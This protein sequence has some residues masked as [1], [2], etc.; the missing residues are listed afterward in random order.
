[1]TL[2]DCELYPA[3]LPPFLLSPPSLLSLPSHHPSSLPPFS[4]PPSFPSSP[5]PPS[6]QDPNVIGTDVS[7]SADCTELRQPRVQFTVEPLI[8][9]TFNQ[10]N[11]TDEEVSFGYVCSRNRIIQVAQNFTRNVSTYVYIHNYILYNY[12]PVHA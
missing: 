4:L 9:A 8:R 5:S 2:F 7:L 1:M 6:P 11:V 3:T 12:V 10:G